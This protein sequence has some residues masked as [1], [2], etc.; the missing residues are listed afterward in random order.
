MSVESAAAMTP[1]PAVEPSAGQP[2][3]VQF[4][5]HGNA[6]IRVTSVLEAR[7]AIKELRL[8]KK[9]YQ[10]AKRAVAAELAEVRAQRRLEVGRQGSMTRGGGE[11]GKI[12]RAF[13]RS[14]RDRARAKY[15]NVVAAYEQE[16]ARIDRNIQ[17]IDLAITQLENYI[18]QH[19]EPPM[20]SR[21]SRK[22]AKMC[23]ECGASNDPTDRYCG[24][25]GKEL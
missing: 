20:S 4:D 12:I 22:R 6:S 13:E 23:S 19:P 8:K 15:A 9:E 16:K 21:S 10:L 11:F 2:G 5:E 14:S 25:C 17:E 18:L 24:T 7:Q 1:T 3:I